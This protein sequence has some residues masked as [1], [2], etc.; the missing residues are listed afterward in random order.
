MS[1]RA[2]Q[3]RCLLL[4]FILVLGLSALSVRLIQIQLWDRAEYAERARAAYDRSE[5][6]K[7]M[8]GSIVDRNDEVLAKS[9]LLSSLMVDAKLLEDPAVVARALAY[10][11]AMKDPDWEQ[12]GE[13]E[14]VTRLSAYRS[15]ILE[16]KEPEQIVNE[17]FDWT[18]ST[19]K[20]PLGLSEEDLRSKIQGPRSLGRAYYS[21]MDDLD[22][23]EADKLRQ[24][25]AEHYFKGFRFQ[26]ELKRIYPSPNQAPHMVGYMGEKVEEGPDGEN[27]FLQVGKFGVEAAM[28]EFLQ[29]QDG[30]QYH[31]NSALTDEEGSIIPPVHGLN[32]QLTVDMGIQ[33]IIEEE[34]SAGLKEFKS[35]RGCVIVLNPKTGGLLA[36]ANRPHFNLNTKKGM[37]DGAMNYALQGIYEPGSTF[38][39]FGIAGAINEGLVNLNTPIY[40]HNGLLVEGKLRVPDHHPY[41]TLPVENVLQKS[42]NPGTF[43]ISRMLGMD[44]FY[45]YLANFGFG[46]KTGIALSG[47]SAGKIRNTGNLIDFSRATYG[48]AVNVTPLQI[49]SAYSAIANGGTLIKPRIVKS[50]VA[51][52]GTILES[53]E[54]EK[55]RRVISE[56]TAG[57][58]REAMV[59]VV[60]EGGTATQAHVEGYKVAGKTGTAL[61]IKNGQ[62]QQGHY[63]VSFAGMMPAEDPAFVCLV[64]IDDPLTEEVSRYGGTI[65]A[66]IFAKIA[67]RLATHMN[68]TPTETVEEDT[69]L[70]DIE[71]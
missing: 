48:Y 21:I 34:L 54:P 52:D 56:K 42:S 31:N 66:P 12:L 3:I 59:K 28:E 1:S 57:L 37:K 19:L 7:G 36:M 46:E 55:V 9:V 8:R 44:R 2:F 45:K 18:V 60:E 62:Y 16:E 35:E 68:L 14:K 58:M 49:A 6:L 51:S 26:N 20:R 5:V 67:S 27:T 70:A 40:C 69:A 10:R 17:Y 47:E 23:D 50:I 25:I 13:S 71:N 22:E 61:R 24:L 4:C 41:G 43:K 15:N 32:V 53:F 29:G 11:D 30:V 39:V 63:T 64:V 38:K 65:A 33:S